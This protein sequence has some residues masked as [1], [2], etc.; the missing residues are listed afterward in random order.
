[1][2]ENFEYAKHI[3]ELN[4]Q[5]KVKFYQSLARHLT[6][7]VRYVYSINIDDKSK[8]QKMYGINEIQHRVI[9]KLVRLCHIENIED[10]IWSES[11]FA[12][13]IK[14]WATRNAIER[15]IEHSVIA[16]YK[17]CLEVNEKFLY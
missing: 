4:L 17:E 13:M 9:A 6:L 16:S 15:Q 2:L 8:C 3:G 7:S 1:M 12:E 5:Q 10:D 11:D 14:S